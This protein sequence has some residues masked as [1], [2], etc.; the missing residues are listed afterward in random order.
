MSWKTGACQASVRRRAIVF[1]VEV[2]SSSSTSPAAGRAAG[3]CRR[4]RRQG[5]LLDVLRDDPALGPRAG[6]LRDVDPLLAREPPCERRRLDAAVG[7]RR[8]GGSLRRRGRGGGLLAAL[9][10]GVHRRRRRT[11][12]LRIVGRL[13]RVVGL[14]CGRAARRR[15][16]PGRH[17]LALAADEGDRAADLDLARVDD[18]LEQHAVGL[19]LDLLCHLVGVE[20]VQRLALLDRVALVLQPLDDRAGL[21]PLAQPWQL[22]LG[23]HGKTLRPYA[24]AI[25]R[26]TASSTSAACGTA[27]CSIAG[28]NASGANF[29]PTRS[30]GASR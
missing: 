13:G 27:H 18:D 23:R 1:R 25:V 17:V 5:G 24:L 16:V 6:D 22:D 28:A 7:P 3:R 12:L 26:L 30:I 8:R 20:L 14:G 4:R 19:G 11:L 10:L 15:A 21:H 2:S 9:A 29:A